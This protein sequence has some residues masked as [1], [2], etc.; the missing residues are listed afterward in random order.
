MR[1]NSSS[2][3]SVSVSRAVVAEAPRKVHKQSLHSP[4]CLRQAP[5][6][7][8]PAVQAVDNSS[9][10][11][12]S[13]SSAEAGMDV[14]ELSVTAEFLK[15][16]ESTEAREAEQ[17]AAAAAESLSKVGDTAVVPDQCSTIP[18]QLHSAASVQ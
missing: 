1:N 8:L 5:A 11:R 15:R 3:C 12:H 2:Y 10:S 4:S 18:L 13:H 9:S 17:A 14:A 6:A 7:V 16:S